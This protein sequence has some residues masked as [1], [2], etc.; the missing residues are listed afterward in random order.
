MSVKK[1][2]PRAW[3]YSRLYDYE[4][5]PQLYKFKAIDRLPE[6]PN[7]AMER[8]IRIHGLAEKALL[9]PRSSLPQELQRLSARFK[10]LRQ[11]KAAPEKQWTLTDAFKG[12]TGWFD[13][14]AWLRLKLD[15][16]V[17]NGDQV[18][19]VDWKTGQFKPEKSLDQLELYALGASVIHPEVKQVTA[20]LS[21]VDVGQEVPVVVEVTQAWRKKITAKWLKRIAPLQ[22]DQKFSPK[23]G[24]ACNWCFFAKS[25]G[26]PC[27]HG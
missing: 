5:C 10:E 21:Y 13:K 7:P 16:V 6:P 4:R 3:S 17:V 25:K 22:K 11:Q 24:P 23:P 2:Q 14:D 20:R 18:E 26:G 8:G 15:A 1:Q 9:Q 27:A 19:V 12:V